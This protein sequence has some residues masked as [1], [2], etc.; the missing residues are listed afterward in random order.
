MKN[1]ILIFLFLF[2]MPTIAKAEQW[3]VV[4]GGDR[5][6]SQAQYE[7]NRAINNRPS[8]PQVAIFYRGGWYRSVILFQGRT[9]AQAAL[10][11]IHTQ[12]RRGSYVINVDD[13]CPNWQNNRGTSKGIRFYRCL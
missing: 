13:W 2:G 3:G 9:E 1:I 4:F 5:D 11:N 6:I 12:L 8:Y 7:I 10:S